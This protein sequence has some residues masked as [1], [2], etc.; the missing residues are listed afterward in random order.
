MHT[1]TTAVDVLAPTREE[2]ARRPYRVR[3]ARTGADVQAAQRLRFRVFNLELGEGLARSYATGRD[4]D[5]FDDVC[6]H[7]IVEDRRS[8][9]VVG[10]YRLQSGT[11]AAAHLGY[12]SDLEFDLTPLEPLR[13]E[14]VEL[15]RACIDARHRNFAV[16]NLLWNGIAEYARQCRARYLI[17]C[18]SLTSTDPA[19]ATAAYRKLQGY[20]AAPS[21]R[22]G[23]R[24][25]FSC[26]PATPC[27]DAPKIPKLLGA[28]LALGAEICGPPAI[29]REFGTID[30]LTWLDLRA[31]G[32]VSLQQRGRF[33][34][35]A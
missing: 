15:G 7:L 11:R 32:L 20:L 9:I 24:A 4:A 17:G 34:G 26:D 12:Y 31:P 27:A 30:F 21:L 6:D 35:G 13:A 29:D 3:L 5:R 33:G 23:P 28:Y 14:I 10:T 25:K 22:V 19:V 2:I 8:G 16:L 1:T 18:S